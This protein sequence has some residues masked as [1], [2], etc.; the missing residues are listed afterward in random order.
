[1]FER[2]CWTEIVCDA[3][4]CIEYFK[5]SA[6]SS[7][8]C[9]FFLNKQI[10]PLLCLFYILFNIISSFFTQFAMINVP[11]KFSMYDEN[12]S[13]GSEKICFHVPFFICVITTLCKYVTFNDEDFFLFKY[14]M[15]P[16]VRF[17]WDHNRAHRIIIGSRSERNLFSVQRTFNLRHG[18]NLSGESL[19]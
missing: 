8:L 1:M 6:W 17:L 14:I 10:F 16:I 13:T 18:N 5:N 12:C 9:I 4:N 7:F 19:K 15:L 3:N 2:D 11:W